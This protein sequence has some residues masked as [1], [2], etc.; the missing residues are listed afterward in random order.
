MPDFFYIC[1]ENHCAAE[2]IAAQPKKEAVFQKRKLFLK[3]GRCFSKKEAVF[4]KR[5]VFFKK[6]RCF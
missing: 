1:Y 4:Q 2:K 6:G 5:K 3:K